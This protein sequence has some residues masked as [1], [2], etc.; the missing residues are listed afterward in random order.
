[1]YAFPLIY[2]FNLFKGCNKTVKRV[3]VIVSHRDSSSAVLSRRL[4]LPLHIFLLFF[5]FLNPKAHPLRN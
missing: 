3:D 4:P 5:S 2:Q 1:M